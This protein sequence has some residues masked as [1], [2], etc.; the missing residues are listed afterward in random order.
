M[1]ICICQNF[2]FLVLN[3]VL[4]CLLQYLLFIAHFDNFFIIKKSA[5]KQKVWLAKCDTKDNN[6][7]IYKK[8]HFCTY[9]IK[10]VK[11]NQIYVGKTESTIWNKYAECN[12]FVIISLQECA[13]NF[14]ALNLKIPCISYKCA[15]KENV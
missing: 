14:M 2:F 6:K 13:P 12:I 11:C 1:C 4:I 8:T 15:T 7:Q 10:Y 9:K 5:N 3:F